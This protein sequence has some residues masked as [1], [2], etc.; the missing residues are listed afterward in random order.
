M[1]RLIVILLARSCHTF[2]HYMESEGFASEPEKA[3]YKN[4]FPLFF[5]EQ[6]KIFICR[7]DTVYVAIKITVHRI[8]TSSFPPKKRLNKKI[9]TR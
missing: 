5:N 7:F 8:C 4:K 9:D 3:F 1:E 2:G 6:D